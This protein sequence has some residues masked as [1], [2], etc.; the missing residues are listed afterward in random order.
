MAKGAAG[1]AQQVRQS[2][3]FIKN[4]PCERR[5]RVQPDRQAY[6]NGQQATLQYKLQLHTHGEGTIHYIG[7]TFRVIPISLYLNNIILNSSPSKKFR[8][9]PSPILAPVDE[10]NNSRLPIRST[11][12]RKCSIPIRRRLPLR[13]NSPTLCFD[14]TLRRLCS[15]LALGGSAA[16]PTFAR[17]ED[18]AA[19]TSNAAK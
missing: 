12:R 1:A 17:G 3:F 9:S 8:R 13:E 4:A 18:F 11:R 10:D 15:A 5:P 6:E 16:S 14:T 2:K 19:A 7:S